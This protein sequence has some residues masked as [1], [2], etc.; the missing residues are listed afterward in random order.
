MVNALMTRISREP[1]CNLHRRVWRWPLYVESGRRGPS[2]LEAVRRE[3][4]DPLVENKT[5]TCQA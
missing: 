4:N 5:S 1:D 2:G 3:E